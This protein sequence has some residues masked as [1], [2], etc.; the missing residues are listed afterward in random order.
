M[1]QFHFRLE[2]LLNYRRLIEKQSQ[3]FLAQAT[4]RLLEEQRAYDELEKKKAD[5]TANFCA[6][7]RQRTVNVEILKTFQFFH[8]KINRDISNQRQRVNEAVQIREERIRALEEAATKRSI[9]ENLKMKH[10]AQYKNEI[11]KEEQKSLDEV[12]I[13]RFLR[14]N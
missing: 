14:G 13:Q 5:S 1:R 4:N 7:Q 6:C 9:V 10:L 8:D 11:L 2:T 3:I 12:G